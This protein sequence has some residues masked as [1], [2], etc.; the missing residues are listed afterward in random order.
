MAGYFRSAPPEDIA[1]AVHFLIGRRPKRLIPTRDLVAWA[2]EE[3]NIPDWLF[4]ESYQAVGDLAETIALLLPPAQATSS[5]SLHEWVEERLLPM[6]DWDDRTRRES[7]VQAWR[8]MSDRQRFVWNKLITG[9]FRVG[10]SQ[11]LVVRALAEASDVDAK[12]LAHRLIGDWQPT[13]DFGA[14]ILAKTTAVTYVSRP[15]PVYLAP[16][17]D[18]TAEEP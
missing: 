13:T 7:M 8:E 6:R 10:V 11:N 5:R 12:V 18:G 15:Y 9:E 4:G 17:L 3:A 14:Q 16:P 1:W 2:L